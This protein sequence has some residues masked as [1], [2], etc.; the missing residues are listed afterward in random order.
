MSAPVKPF[1]IGGIPTPPGV[2]KYIR[3]KA[4]ES[5]TATPIFI[6]VTVVHGVKPGPRLFVTA[7][8]HGDEINGVEAIRRLMLEVDPKK[9]SGTLVLVPVA[10][11]IGFME[12]KRDLPDGRD[13]NRCFPGSRSGSL[14]SQLAATLFEKIVLQ[15]DYGIDL[16]TASQGRT[17]LPHVRADMGQAS[18]R[19]LVAAF[20]PEFILDFPGQPRMLRT[21]A[22]R[23]GVPVITVEAGEP[24]RFQEWAITRTVAGLK[25]VMGDLGM[26]AFRRHSPI[27]QMVLKDRTWLRA[28]RGGILAM[29]VRLGS[30]VERDQEIARIAKPYGIHASLMRAPFTGVVVGLSTLPMVYPGSAVC[31]LLRLTG[32]QARYRKLLETYRVAAE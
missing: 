28:R 6:P 4:S 21:V 25:N 7:T 14:G 10:N 23:R 17:N 15:C 18:A 22:A 32:R 19:R 11:P 2:R 26:V 31:H 16:H 3:L 27:F 13:L 5:F 20:G 30:V 9:L 8:I 1:V 24:M 29:L 12:L